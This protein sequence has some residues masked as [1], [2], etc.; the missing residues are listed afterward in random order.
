MNGLLPPFQVDLKCSESEKERLSVELNQLKLLIHDM[1]KLRSENQEL[2]KSLSQQEVR[3]N[4]P[5]QDYKVR[6]M[7]KCPLIVM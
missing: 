2:R 3:H 6:P 1:E 5:D 7:K 4:R